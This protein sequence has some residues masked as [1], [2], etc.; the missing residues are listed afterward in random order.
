MSIYQLPDAQ[1]HNEEF[2]ACLLSFALMIM[3]YGCSRNEKYF[4]DALLLS[5]PSPA[6][7]HIVECVC[8]IEVTTIISINFIS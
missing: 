2:C 1:Y 5:K 8:S 6:V 7:V 3:R 4:F